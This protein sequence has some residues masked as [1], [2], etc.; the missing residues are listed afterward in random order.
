M[1]A[2]DEILN[3]I[4]AILARTGG[5]VFSIGAVII[6]LRRRGSAYTEATIRTHVASRMCSSAPYDHAKTYDDF[7][8]VGDGLYRLA[9]RN[10]R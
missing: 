8:S 1:T 9:P 3:A 7:K 10:H 5:E 2:R 4:P 6:E